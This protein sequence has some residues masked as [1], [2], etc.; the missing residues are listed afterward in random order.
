MDDARD[1]N[2]ESTETKDLSG[3]L[4]GDSKVVDNEQ[5]SDQSADSRFGR[6]SI[7]SALNSESSESESHDALLFKLV[8]DSVLSNLSQG[9]K[10]PTP[11]KFD[12]K[13]FLDSLHKRLELQDKKIADLSALVW[14][15]D[16]Q[17]N[18]NKAPLHRILAVD[19]LHYSEKMEA[20]PGDLSKFTLVASDK[21]IGANWHPIEAKADRKWRW[22]GPGNTSTLV[23]PNL[24]GGKLQF[25]MRLNTPPWIDLASE[26]EFTIGRRRFLLTPSSEKGLWN[27]TVVLPETEENQYVV[28]SIRVIDMKS[29]ATVPNFDKRQIGVAF[30]SLTI[31]K[32]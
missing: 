2:K 5:T 26:V 28:L 18:V 31:T 6:I 30:H 14:L 16:R 22:S 15:M 23:I 24:K 11:K 21:M 20:D 10:I 13:E 8:S 25:S 1:D 9:N 12:D 19:P 32:K 3:E 27:A 17:L 29:P 4:K 7:E